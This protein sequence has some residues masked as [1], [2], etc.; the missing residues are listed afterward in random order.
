M[1]EA[2]GD[3][4]GALP[5]Q[6]AAR[7]PS[8]IPGT[9]SS[10]EGGLNRPPPPSCPEH[11][12]G[13]LGQLDRP[14]SSSAAD[15]SGA[16]WPFGPPPARRPRAGNLWHRVASHRIALHSTPSWRRTMAAIMASNHGRVAAKSS[17]ATRQ[18]PA[19]EAPTLRDAPPGRPDAG[20]ATAAAA[21]PPP[22]SPKPGARRRTPGRL[23]RPGAG[24]G[25][26]PKIGPGRRRGR[27]GSRPTGAIYYCP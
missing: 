17:P 4:R 3:I 24:R 12:S 26:V 27:V 20:G 9:S 23:R 16:R 11:C 5:R 1:P 18:P 19:P 10:P 25:G 22:R 7:G 2:G 21:W 8:P 15:K 13:Q 14:Q 6:R